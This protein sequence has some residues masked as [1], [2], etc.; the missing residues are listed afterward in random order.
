MDP[1]FSYAVCT[2]SELML[3]VYTDA[4]IHTVENTHTGFEEMLVN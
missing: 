3:S 4:H 1:G 2:L